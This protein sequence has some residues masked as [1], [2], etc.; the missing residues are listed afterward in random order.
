MLT[1]EL[2]NPEAPEYFGLSPDSGLYHH[3]AAIPLLK[4]TLIYSNPQ[5]E[6]PVKSTSPN[7]KQDQ[8][9]LVDLPAYPLS[10]RQ[11]A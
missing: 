10:L 9:Q 1:P 2:E 7:A 5:D 4:G 8:F 6:A 11:Y 3:L